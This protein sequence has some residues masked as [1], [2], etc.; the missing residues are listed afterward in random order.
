MF[1]LPRPWAALRCVS[2][3]PPVALPN[4]GANVLRCAAPARARR[5]RVA[6]G[7]NFSTRTARS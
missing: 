4:R 6:Y 7:T 5:F 3:R 2:A 1:A